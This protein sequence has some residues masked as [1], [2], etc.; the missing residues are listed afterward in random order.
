MALFGLRLSLLPFLL[1]QD[2]H[3]SPV[4]VGSGFAYQAEVEAQKRART[5]VQFPLCLLL[6]SETQLAS[7][8]VFPPTIF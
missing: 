6:I 3:D 8:T 7:P 2:G 1:H 5:V 4:Q